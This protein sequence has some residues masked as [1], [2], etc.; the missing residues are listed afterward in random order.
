[1]RGACFVFAAFLWYLATT[2]IAFAANAGDRITVQRA[3]EPFALD[4]S[5]SDPRWSAALRPVVLINVAGRVAALDAVEAA[6]FYDDRNVYVGFRLIQSAPLSQTQEVNNIGFGIDD[7]IGI[8][9]DPVGNG[10]RAYWF[11]TTPRGV[12]YQQANENAR[13]LPEWSAAGRSAAGG[14]SAILIIPMSVMKIPA[15][16]AQHWRINFER[17]TAATGERDTWAFNDLMSNYPVAQFPDFRES[18]WWPTVSGMVLD[19]AVPRPK[20]RAEIFGLSTSGSDREVYT[21]VSGTTYRTSPRYF[22]LDASYPLE[23]TVNLDV[24]LSPDFSNVE[25]D[26]QTISPQQFRR[27]F[28]EYRPFF[29]QGAGY[30]NTE[31]ENYEFNFP[32]D[33]IFYSPSIGLFDRGVKLEGTRGTNSFGVLEAAGDDPSGPQNFDDIAFGFKHKRLDNTL[34]VWADGVMAHHLGIHDSTFE[35]GA[36]GRSLASGLVYSI[37]HAAEYGSAITNPGQA[38]KTNALF[39]IQKSGPFEATVGWVQIGS[40]YNPVDGFTNI[41][42]VRGPDM[43]VDWVITPKNWTAI[44]NYEFYL[45]GDRWIDSQGQVHESDADAYFN[46]RTRKLLTMNFGYQNA[47]QRSYG[48]NFYSGYYNNYADAITQRLSAPFVG[49]T[50]GDGA[51]NS[52]A[53]NYQWGP[54]AG[55]YLTQITT[56]TIYQIGG[57]ASFEFDYA[58]DLERPLAGGAIN[59]QTLWRATLGIPMGRDGNAAF[60]YRVISGTGGFAAPGKN[61]ALALRRRFKNGNEVFVNYGTPAADSTLDRLIVKYLLRIG[62]GV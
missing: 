30:I 45:F 34:A 1:M 20:P 44:K 14:W 39:D 26:Q 62:G 22:G 36:Y 11:E 33:Q 7:F 51:P 3:A 40:Q 47:S 53:A 29:A 43:Q 31:L 58:A 48:G 16:G 59:G 49:F 5:L 38:Q 19:R 28:H 17:Y 9:L 35:V 10:E 57:R 15:N 27:N 54:F 52:F 32:Q 55:N 12:R 56:T 2:S 24:A 6:V 60:A 61:L 8:G 42:D 41:A 4:A 46:V 37:D 50:I 23:P 13:Y 18:R 21:T 25:V